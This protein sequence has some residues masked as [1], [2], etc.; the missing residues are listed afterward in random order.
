MGSALTLFCS[1]L[2][3]PFRGSALEKGG[4]AEI[5]DLGWFQQKQHGS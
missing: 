4:A 2:H 5:R 1:E 3:Q